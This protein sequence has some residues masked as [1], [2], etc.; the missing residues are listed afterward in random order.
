MTKAQS[1]GRNFCNRRFLISF[2]SSDSPLIGDDSFAM[3]VDV[4]EAEGVSSDDANLLVLGSC[5]EGSWRL[6]SSKESSLP[7][8]SIFT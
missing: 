8:S 1:V 4:A 7:T 6:V 3:K 5:V 2:A